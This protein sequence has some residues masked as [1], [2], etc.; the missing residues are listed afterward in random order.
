MES[1]VIGPG[2]LG[3]LRHLGVQNSYLTKGNVLGMHPTPGCY[4]AVSSETMDFLDNLENSLKNLEQREERDGSAAL[5]QNEARK[6]AQEA[7]PWAEKL[8]KSQYTTGLMEQAAAAG[9][10]IRAKIYMAWLDTVLRLEVKGRWCELRPT[11]NGIVA[12]FVNPDGTQT[13]SPVDL[14]G[15]PG[16]LLARWLGE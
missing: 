9:H 15:Q 2:L 7:A 12:E 16:E 5:R 13:S 14:S 3:G 1:N 11:P 6:Q 10:R 8:R 4:D